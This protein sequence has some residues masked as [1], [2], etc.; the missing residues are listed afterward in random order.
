MGIETLATEIAGLT[1]EELA[2]LADVLMAQFNARAEKL[3]WN[4]QVSSTD[5]ALRGGM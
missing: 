4:L 2:K 5:Q 1:N 3:A